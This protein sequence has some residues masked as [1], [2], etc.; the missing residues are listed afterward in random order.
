VGERDGEKSDVEIGIGSSA[1]ETTASTDEPGPKARHLADVFAWKCAT[2]KFISCDE[3]KGAR[4]GC[5]FKLGTEG[6]GCH[7]ETKKK[8]S[9]KKV[10]ASQQASEVTTVA[11][12]DSGEDSP[13]SSP[14]NNAVSTCADDFVSPGELEQEEHK[15]KRL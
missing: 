10:S 5:C 14:Q 15:A 8:K 11:E 12:T 2:G 1:G 4:E 13:P 7:A 3:F 6:V 9:S